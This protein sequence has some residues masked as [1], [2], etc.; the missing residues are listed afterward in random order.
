MLDSFAQVTNADDEDKPAA[1]PAP[2]SDEAAQN[3][4]DAPDAG[5]QSEQ[6]SKDDDED[7]DDDDDNSAAQ[8][9]APSAVS[10]TDIR[11]HANT[12]P[13]P[14]LKDCLRANGQLIGGTKAELV[15]RVADGV[16]H[17]ALQKCT[18][19]GGGRLHPTTKKVPAKAFRCKGFFDD[20]E[21]R[22][23]GAKFKAD[24]VERLPW[25]ASGHPG[26]I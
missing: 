24:E 20:D 11:A 22:H 5:A 17:G 15:M 2:V 4:T 3:S 13:L 25:K 7:D 10:L 26:G 21:F 16:L 14:T 8:S 12:L 6:D 9:S 19:C 1:T 18:S 23:C